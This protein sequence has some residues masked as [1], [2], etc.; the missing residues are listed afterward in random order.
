MSQ[1]PLL[2]NAARH[3][4]LYL[5]YGDLALLSCAG[6]D[7][8]PA[9]V[10]RVGKTTLAFNSSIFAT[11]LTLPGGAD[12]QEMYEGAPVVRLSDTADDLQDLLKALYD[13]S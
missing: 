5:P 12:G 9:T 1:D 2:N 8:G 7:G 4:T 3:P 10:F 11:M 13:P 6:V